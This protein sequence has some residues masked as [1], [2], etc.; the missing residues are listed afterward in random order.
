MEDLQ[1]SESK[2]LEVVAPPFAAADSDGSADEGGRVLHTITTDED[3]DDGRTMTVIEHL[4]ELRTRILRGIAY[5]C[6]TFI[7]ALFFT[8]DILRLLEAPA[9]NITFQALTIEE[10]LIVFFKV[11]FYVAIIAASPLLLWEA[12]RFVSPGLTRK[13]RSVLA[14]IVIGGPLLFVCGGL[15]AYTFLLP[16]MLHFFNSFGQGVA[17]IH[18]R[19]DFYISLVSSILLYMG[20]CF[21]M[22]IIIFALAMAGIV[23]SNMLIKVWR[24]AVFGTTVV[25][26]IIT[27]DPTAFSMLIVMA[28]LNGLYLLS[29]ILLKCARK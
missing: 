17:P 23:T 9:G 25:A 14:P 1:I 21:Q 10:P 11:A 19:L 7:G 18:Q 5:V 16:P 22:P 29:I 8:K 15:F 13:E 24:Y 3:I 28:A 12:S 26:C 4:D 27:P 20:L 6:V 2:S